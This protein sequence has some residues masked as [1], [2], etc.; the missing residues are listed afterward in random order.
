M[1]KTPRWCRKR[2]RR[3]LRNQL[4]WLNASPIRRCCRLP[5]KG[6]GANVVEAAWPAS[7]T[8]ELANLV[9]S[10]TSGLCTKAYR[11][12]WLRCV[13]LHCTACSWSLAVIPTKIKS[14]NKARLA[15][16]LPQQ[17]I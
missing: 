2:I 11:P 3:F 12:Y 14:E 17:A 9:G 13:L 5:V 10:G 6:H 4:A 8:H 16:Q 7:Y 1:Q 15:Q